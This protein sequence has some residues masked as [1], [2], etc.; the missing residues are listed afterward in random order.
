M[1]VNDWWLID[2]LI[3]WLVDNANF[4]LYR[5]VNLTWATVNVY[6]MIH[7]ATLL[8]VLIKIKVVVTLLETNYLIE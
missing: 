3:D 2:W 1:D 4:Q 5:G 6:T 7:N 8:N